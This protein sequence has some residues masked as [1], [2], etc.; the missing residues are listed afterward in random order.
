MGSKWRPLWPVLWA[1]CPCPARRSPPTLAQR[2]SCDT[3]TACNNPI[4]SCPPFPLSVVLPPMSS[5]SQA[6]PH[7]LPPKFYPPQPKPW[8]IKLMQGLSGSIAHW[9]YRM[10]LVVSPEDLACLRQLN[11]DRVV[12]FA[13]HPTFGEPVLL[14]N[15]S[16][17]LHKPFYYMAAY[18][19]FQGAM[20]HF[21]QGV[22]VYS[23]RRGLLDRASL[24]QTIDLLLEP[25][26]HLVIFPEGRCSFQSDRLMAFQPGG[27][28]LAFQALG[29][30]AKQQTKPPDLY[31]VPISIYY[32][33]EGDICAVLDETLTELEAALSLA[34]AEQSSLY[35]RLRRVAAQVF[36]RIEADYDLQADELPALDP[37]NLTPRIDALRQVILQRCEQ[38]LGLPVNLNQPRRDRAYRIQAC[39]QE[40]KLAQGETTLPAPPASLAATAESTSPA[41][42]DLD[43]LQRSV[44]RLLNLDTIYDGYVAEHPTPERFLDTLARFQRELFQVDQP[45]PKRNR[46]A[47]LKVGEPINLKHL[48]EDYGRDRAAAVERTNQAIKAAIQTNLSQLADDYGHPPLDLADGAESS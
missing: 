24:K 47:H 31:A 30:L 40:I 15:L 39:L 4:V 3:A 48:W 6:L 18:E 17:K 41:Q 8:L 38:Q 14:Y 21:F 46:K 29:K 5:A 7:S 32:R 37:Q 42:P 19:L 23:I 27:I 34:P 10:D 22:G 12:L 43:L 2:S 26:C 35:A 36:A 44:E 11:G 13:N 16:S 45:R 9:A 20:R 1:R 25:G 28:Q 33:S